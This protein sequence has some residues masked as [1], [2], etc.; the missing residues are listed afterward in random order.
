MPASFPSINSHSPGVQSGPDLEPERRHRLRDC[1]GAAN[2]RCRPVERREE[3]VA[4]RV[5]L[6]AAEA[7]E[8]TSDDRVVTLDEVAPTLVADA[9]GGL[10]GLDDVGEENGREH[11]IGF[12]AAANSGQELLHL[13]EHRVGVADP[14]QVVAA[15]ELHDARAGDSRADHG[16][17]VRR[18][19]QVLAGGS[20]R[21]GAVTETCVLP[22]E[23]ERRD[24]DGREHRADVDL[25]VHP[26]QR[27]RC[28]RA[29]RVAEERAPPLPVTLVARQ[30]RRR[31]RRVDRVR[32]A[33][34]D[35]PERLLELLARDHPSSG[36]GERAVEHECERPLGMGRG[37]QRAHRAAL[38]D[39][40]QRRALG[41]RRVHHRANVADPLLEDRKLVHRHP[42]G[43]THAALV[44]QQQP[45]ERGE[46]VEE[47]SLSRILP[48]ELD[49]THPTGNEDEVDRPLAEDLVGDVDVAALRVPRLGDHPASLSERDV[50]VNRFSRSRYRASTTSFNPDSIFSQLACECSAASS[51]SFPSWLSEMRVFGPRGSSS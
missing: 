45:R 32:P 43:E 13:A 11:P 29:R 49:V 28:A 1:A 40:E 39:T 36:P 12:G 31:D 17:L 10:R 15:R 51:L 19:H 18:R 16:R 27:D 7:L 4:R 2:P 14:G 33:V 34:F 6:A 47:P 48:G 50:P 20:P 46:A 5:D 21:C 8:L 30:A 23:D 38:G 3:P 24:M 42:V 9:R 26:M 22:V 37:E 41:A 35:L 25:A 44:E